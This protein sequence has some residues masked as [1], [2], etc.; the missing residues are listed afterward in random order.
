MTPEPT[1]DLSA[2]DGARRRPPAG[3]PAHKLVVVA[4]RLPVRL[5]A[6]GQWIASPGGLVRALGPVLQRQHGAWVGW[7]GEP[8]EAP[9]P[10][11]HDGIDLAPVGMTEE[12]HQRFYE[13]FSNE[14]LWPLYHD[15][16][17]PSTFD[18]TW[19]DAYVAVNHRFAER[20]A[21]LVAPGGQVWVHDYH[22]QLV[23]HY[24]RELR[25]DTRIGFFLHIPFP[26]Q[27]L[28]MRLPWRQEIARALLEADVIGFQRRMG[29]EN[30]A[31]IC[32]RLLDAE[33]EPPCVQLEDRRV[34]VRAYPISID[35]RE[36][37]RVAGQPDTAERVGE[38]RSRLGSPR[39]VLAGV[40]RLDYTK[41]IDVRLEA[42]RE[43][44]ARRSAT[45]SDAA[46]Y[47]GPDIVMVQVAVPS[48]EGVG[49]Y[50]AERE[51]VEQLVG[52]INGDYAT[53]GRPAVHYLHRSLPFEAL[54]ALYRAADVMVVTP[55]RD[56]MN[57]VAKEFVASR[58]HDDGVLV[59]SEFAGAADEL[60]E[61]LLVNSHDLG[62]V[63][64]VLD[65]AVDLDADEASRRMRALREV[66][67]SNDVDRW[68]SDFLADLAAAR[69]GATPAE[70]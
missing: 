44:L 1:P 58:V 13:G 52:E 25:P 12:E 50:A 53:V 9:A 48:R 14:T 22:L 31:A 2:T 70:R 33:G 7:A 64:D 51:R 30:F 55:L 40:D 6:E 43:L 3:E 45:P 59:L 60:T 35:V 37:E 46:G 24:L 18:Q 4:N 67:R 56:G 8:G 66:V 10:F 49:A 57:L 27:E 61:A 16:I 54:V 23:P 39:T 38:L 63:V 11:D 19:W 5:G 20:A 62:A 28:F 41:G 36:F 21:E 32:R 26:P 29:A 42:F 69:P 34:R 17:R 65:H 47:P 15:A 68:A